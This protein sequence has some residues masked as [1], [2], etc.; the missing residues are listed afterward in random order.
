L[1]HVHIFCDLG[2]GLIVGVLIN[3]LFAKMFHIYSVWSLVVFVVLCAIPLGLLTFKYRNQI[4]IASTSITGAYFIIRPISWV[5]GGFPN[6]FLLYHLIETNQLKTLHWTFFL[7]L[8][9]IIALAI[10]GGM[11]QLLYFI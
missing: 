10:V 7:Y 5:A 6:E 4:I 2:L 3:S 11:Y 8:I 9:F 1:E